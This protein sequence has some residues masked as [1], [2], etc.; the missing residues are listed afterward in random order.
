MWKK[1]AAEGKIRIT[2]ANCI[3]FAQGFYQKV[4]TEHLLK[5][6]KQKAGRK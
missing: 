1:A 3:G 4:P 2:D 6:L 5:N